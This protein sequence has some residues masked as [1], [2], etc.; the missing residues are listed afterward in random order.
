MYS[1]CTSNSLDRFSWDPT[2]FIGSE[3]SGTDLA[4]MQLSIR[5][6]AYEPEGSSG[7]QWR[8]AGVIIARV[9]NTARATLELTHDALANRSS[10]SREMLKKTFV[11]FSAEVVD[12]QYAKPHSY[13]VLLY[14]LVL[15]LRSP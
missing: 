15:Y 1:I 5:L 11:V 10:V 3:Q 8:D 2:D 4:D 6:L 7:R 12:P 9:P 14:M 13:T